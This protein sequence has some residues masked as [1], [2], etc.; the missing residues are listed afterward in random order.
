MSLKPFKPEVI[1]GLSLNGKPQATVV[2]NDAC[3]LPMNKN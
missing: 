3:G 2:L 1:S